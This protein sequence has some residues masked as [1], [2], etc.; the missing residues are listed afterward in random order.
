MISFITFLLFHIYIQ[1]F[2]I[3]GGVISTKYS[4]MACSTPVYAE[5]YGSKLTK[6]Y[7]TT[8]QGFDV[9]CSDPFGSG[10]QANTCYWNNTSCDGRSDTCYSLGSKSTCAA[11]TLDSGFFVKAWCGAVAS[12]ESFV[13]SSS[14]I[15]TIQK[16]EKADC[17]GDLIATQYFYGGTCKKA[18]SI[19]VTFTCTGDV[20]TENRYTNANCTGTP[21]TGTITK[22]CGAGRKLVSC[23]YTSF[24]NKLNL[25]YGGLVIVL[26]ILF[27]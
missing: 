12:S 16:Y 14:I 11:S 19:Y 25:F 13:S 9:T 27:L 4:E 24:S 22:T 18:G 17:T 8:Q 20:L 3:D 6:C 15:S 21:S 2:N 10:Y 23:S 1:Q 7:K 26:G 5:L